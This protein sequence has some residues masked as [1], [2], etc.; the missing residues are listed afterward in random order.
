MD[1]WRERIGTRRERMRIYIVGMND[2]VRLVRA[3]NRQQAVSHVA[4]QI[5]VAKVATQDELVKHITEG[6]AVE[7]YKAPDQQELDLGE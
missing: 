4:R 2:G 1:R 7:N 3:S 6:V 5:I